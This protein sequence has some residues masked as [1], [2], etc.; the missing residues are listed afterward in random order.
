MHLKSGYAVASLRAYGELRQWAEV[1]RKPRGRP[2]DTRVAGWAAR[3]EVPEFQD[4]PELESLRAKCR[5]LAWL[6]YLE[7]GGDPD[8][9]TTRQLVRLGEARRV[10][11]LRW[12]KKRR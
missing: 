10:A 9:L 2:R 4:D 5:R 11:L 8:T 3:I 6:E 12:Y 7:G 1:I